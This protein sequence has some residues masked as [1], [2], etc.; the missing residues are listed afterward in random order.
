VFVNEQFNRYTALTTAVPSSSV[1]YPWSLQNGA[2]SVAGM[3]QYSGA[4]RTRVCLAFAGGTI[5]PPPELAKVGDTG[6]LLACRWL[7]INGDFTGEQ[8]TIVWWVQASKLAGRALVCLATREE[9]S[10]GVCFRTDQSGNVDPAKLPW[11]EE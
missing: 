11:V 4:N 1:R 3:E 5:A 6:D 8:S 10:R 7:V 2:F 9:P